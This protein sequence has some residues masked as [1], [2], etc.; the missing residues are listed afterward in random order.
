MQFDFIDTWRIK[1]LK[2]CICGKKVEYISPKTVLKFRFLGL[3][4][5]I[6]TY[7]SIVKMPERKG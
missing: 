3:E 4:E 7:Y 5:K 2:K 6:K 1:K